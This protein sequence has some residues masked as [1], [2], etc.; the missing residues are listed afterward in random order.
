MGQTILFIIDDVHLEG[1]P[2]EMQ[3]SFANKLHEQI[4]KCKNDKNIPIL[5]CAGD[6]SEN[7]Q[8]MEWLVQFQCDT[9]YICGNHEFWNHDYYEVID[10]LKAKSK[11]PGFEKIHFLHNEEKIIHGIRFLGSTLWT[12]LAQNWAWIKKNYV[13]KHFMSMADFRKITARKFYLNS[14]KVDE[15]FKFLVKNGVEPDVATNLIELESFNPYLQIE[16]NSTS[17]DFLENKIIEPFDG[18]TIVVSHH[19]PIPDFWMKTLGMNEN[20]L[21][22]PY[23]NNKA[24]Y[25]E[26]LKQKI[27]AEKDIL[28]MGFYVNSAYQFFEHNFAPDIWIHG[29]FHKEIDGYIGTTRMVS[30]PVGYMR[31]SEDF[32]V[33][34][35]IIGNEI[36]NYIDDAIKE[37]NNFDWNVKVKDTLN[38]FKN[39]IYDIAK[40]INEKEI[41]SDTFSPVLMAFKTQHDK[42]L[43]DVEIFVSNLFY[44]LIKLIDP[45]TTILDQIYM[46]SYISGFGKWAAKQGKIGIDSFSLNTSEVSFISENKYNKIKEKN[47]NYLEHYK[48]WLT[49]LDMIEEQVSHFKTSLIAYFIFLKTQNL[50]EITADDED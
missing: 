17:I 15:M 23:I 42:N 16:E 38:Q 5:I 9:I 4:L 27:P 34:Q 8:G 25:K 40:V 18:K 29:H 48:E 30:S 45:Q 2:I 21:T 31:Q 50:L 20:I 39:F 49:E 24:V 43:K 19:L 26:Y 47:D 37:I 10:N 14:T 46:T 12:E 6:I 36:T 3:N 35:I 33:K 22:S 28:M 1:R 41:K 44:N 7:T 11:E 13:V 32:K